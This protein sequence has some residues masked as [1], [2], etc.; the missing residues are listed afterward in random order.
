MWHKIWITRWIIFFIRYTRLFIYKYIIKKHE[1][2]TDYHPIRIYVNKIKNRI[3]FKIETGYNLE[4]LKWWNYFKALK[5]K[6]TD[7]ENGEKVPHL[8][9]AEVDLVQY[10]VV[11]SDY[12]HESKVLFT[13]VPNKYLVSY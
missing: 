5:S 9:V 12:Q 13:F 10:N 4:H 7:N 3:T 6:I 8:E 11:D 1:K 2:V